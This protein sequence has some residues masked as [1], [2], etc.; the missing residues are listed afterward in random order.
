MVENFSSHGDFHVSKFSSAVKFIVMAEGRGDIYLHL[1]RSME[2]DIASGS[3]LMEML[4]GKL[5]IIENNQQ[6]L[7]ISNQDLTYRK[8]D[9][10]N[11]FFL[12]SFL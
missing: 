2:W 4:G 6:N 11:P 1:R 12:V 7:L 10:V 3:V 9:F 8:A 5:N